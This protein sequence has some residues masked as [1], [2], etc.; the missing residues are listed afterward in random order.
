MVGKI[1][2]I[3]KNP[4]FSLTFIEP[5]GFEKIYRKFILAETCWTTGRA[6]LLVSYWL[7]AFSWG[8]SHFLQLMKPSGDTLGNA[9]SGFPL[10]GAFPE[11]STYSNLLTLFTPQVKR[12]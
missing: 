7:A 12:H 8:F 3:E 6:D 2:V 4:A 5:W 1:M 10:Y 9:P 11:V